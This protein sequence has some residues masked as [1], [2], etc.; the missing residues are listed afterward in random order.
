MIRI[1]KN[2]ID[3]SSHVFEYDK[4]GVVKYLHIEKLIDDQS[5]IYYVTDMTSWWKG[6]HEV[7]EQVEIDVLTGLYNRRGFTRRWNSCRI[8][9]RWLTDMMQL[10]W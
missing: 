4:D 6:F 7:K 10:L 5:T 1:E 2:V 9:P 3:E 8:R